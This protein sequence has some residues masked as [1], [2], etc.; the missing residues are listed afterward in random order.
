M[1]GSFMQG[2]QEAANGSDVEV[3]SL[4]DSSPAE[5]MFASQESIYEKAKR[6][7]LD[8]E[9]TDF[10]KEKKE[11]GLHVKYLLN[12]DDI[13]KLLKSEII[14][15]GFGLEKDSSGM[16]ICKLISDK[17][18]AEESMAQLEEF[19]AQAQMSKDAPEGF[20]VPPA[21]GMPPDMLHQQKMMQEAMLEA[22]KNLKMEFLITMPNEIIEVKGLFEKVDSKTASVKF[23]GN[24]IENPE[25]I[26]KL[27]GTSGQESYVACSGDGVTFTSDGSGSLSEAENNVDV[28]VVE[29]DFMEPVVAIESS[30]EQELL[31]STPTETVTIDETSVEVEITEGPIT[32]TKQEVEGKKSRVYLNTGSVFEGI[33]T[34]ETDE[35][36]I[37]NM[38]GIPFEYLRSEV[39][40]IEYIDN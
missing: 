13:N 31:V 19:K 40:R 32:E 38:R 9:F 10:K 4:T 37:I 39:S 29:T 17:K 11:D 27:Y 2:M 1:L 12:F 28:L 22:L 8:I 15:T 5:E 21:E 23:S 25:L 33:I 18:K 14:G 3:P 30:D 26:K 35:Y 24:L 16:L 36:I 6:A 20:P 34:E 7:G